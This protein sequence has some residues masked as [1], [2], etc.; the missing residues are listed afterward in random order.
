MSAHL[1]PNA[2][3]LKCDAAIAKGMAV[4][5]GTDRDHVV[6]SSVATSLS[7]GLAMNTTTTAEDKVEVALPGGG[8]KALLVGSVSF[9][10]LLAPDSTGK[11]V[12]TTTPGDRYIAMAMEDGV[13]GDLIAVH[14]VAGLI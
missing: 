4:K 13:A 7:I 14:V 10:D 9:G 12:A 1:Q 2:L 6:K 11:L 3:T 8:A 5:P